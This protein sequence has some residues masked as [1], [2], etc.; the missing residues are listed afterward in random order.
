MTRPISALSRWPIY[1]QRISNLNYKGGIMPRLLLIL[2]GLLVLSCEIDR[3]TGPDL[4]GYVWDDI[5]FTQVDYDSVIITPGEPIVMQNEM[6]QSVVLYITEQGS[7]GY[8]LLQTVTPTYEKTDDGFLCSFTFYQKVNR[9]LLDLDIKIVYKINTLGHRE[10]VSVDAVHPMYK[11]PYR[12]TE[13]FIEVSQLI[14]PLNGYALSAQDFDMYN[15]NTIFFHDFGPSDL[16]R[17]NTQTDIVESVYNWGAGDYVAYAE[18]YVFVEET[19]FIWRYNLEEEVEDLTLNI[20]DYSFEYLLGTDCYDD[21]LFLVTLDAS[22]TFY[23]VVFDLDFNHLQTEIL[24]YDKGYWLSV[25]NGILYTL[26]YPERLQR[27][28]YVNGQSLQDFRFPTALG[29]GFRIH[30][31]KLY[32][33][34]HSRDAIFSILLADLQPADE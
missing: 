31:N 21:Q 4:S 14:D 3:N 10:D 33:A 15:Q 27:Y 6:V 17:Y 2:A 12:N 1:N 7:E 11:Y 20:R 23:M 29:D 22:D 32:F 13:L 26:N 5:T 25:D 19:G 34:E 30:E 18:N 28:D 9:R 16:F 8:Q 24:P